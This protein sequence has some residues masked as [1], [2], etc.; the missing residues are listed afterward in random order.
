VLDKAGNL[1][2][3]TQG[4]GGFGKVYRLS[5]GKKGLTE[6]TLYS[7]KRGGYFSLGIVLDATGNIYGA[8]EADTGTIFELV[9]SAGK[10]KYQEKF[11]WNFDGTDGALPVGSLILDNAGNLYGTTYDGGGSVYGVVFEVSP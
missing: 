2:G 8:T 7:L 4:T 3:V 5:A 1:Y 9:P 6:K 11:L 10:G